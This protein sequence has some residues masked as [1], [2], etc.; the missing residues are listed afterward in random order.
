[1][2]RGDIVIVD[3]RSIDPEAK[4]RPALVLQNDRDNV[5]MSNTILAQITSNISRAAQDTQY[6]LDGSHPD[7]KQSGLRYPSVVNCST[8]YTAKQ[9][10]ATTVIGSL[11]DATML[12]IEIGLKAALGMKS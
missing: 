7:W 4:V 1:M 8:I 11:S 6:L 10:R 9:Q 3:L 12:E 2:K 5:R